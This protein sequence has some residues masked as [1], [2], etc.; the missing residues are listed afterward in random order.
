MQ[1]KTAVCVCVCVCVAL[2]RYM[3]YL[4]PQLQQ[5]GLYFTAILNSS[6]MDCLSGIGKMEINKQNQKMN[7]P[8]ITCL[9][10]QGWQTVICLSILP[11]NVVTMKSGTLCWHSLTQKD[12]GLGPGSALMWSAFFS[13]SFNHHYDTEGARF[14][15]SPQR[16]L[17]QWLSTWRIP[18]PGFV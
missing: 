15:P 10:E 14:P 2:S 9:K 17:K 11:E 4:K 8:K 1:L 7:I 5:Q 16:D 3:C 18:F 13:F 12:P 6:R